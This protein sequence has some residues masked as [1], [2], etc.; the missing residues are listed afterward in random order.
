VWLRETIADPLIDSSLFSLYIYQNYTPF[1][2]EVEECSG[3][4]EWLTWVDSSGGEA[5]C[6]SLFT[7]LLD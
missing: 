6:V 3:V 2:T 4:A 1:C 5:V 7:Q